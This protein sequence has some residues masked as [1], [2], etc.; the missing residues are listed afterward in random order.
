MQ[1][2]C[3]ATVYL[4]LY[5]NGTLRTVDADLSAVVTS[6]AAPER[7]WLS[8][9]DTISVIRDLSFGVPVLPAGAVPN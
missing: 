7:L 5:V 3:R 6:W 9:G 8:E 4:R 1:T 2:C